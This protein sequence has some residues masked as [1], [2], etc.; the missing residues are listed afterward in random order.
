MPTLEKAIMI[1]ARAHSGQ[2]DKAGQPYILHPLR[3]MLQVSGLHERMAAVLHDVVEDTDMTLEDL[4]GEGFPEAVIKAVEAL[5]KRKGE[6]RMQAAKRAAANPMARAV[7]T[8]DVTDDMNLD[9]I[10][11][12]TARDSLRLKEYEEVLALLASYDAI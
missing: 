7:K 3:V 10:K 11:R 2:V 6:T 1:A 8:A 5:T 4:A 9:R 12:P